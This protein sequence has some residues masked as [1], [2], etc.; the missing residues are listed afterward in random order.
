M[1]KLTGAALTLALLCMGAFA[2]CAPM[3]DI[4]GA[5]AELRRNDETHVVI[6]VTAGDEKKSLYDA[7]AV[8]AQQGDIT[9]EGSGGAGDFF[10]TSVNGTQADT[11]NFWAVY[12][13]LEAYSDATWG[14][15]E[16][17]GET[18]ASAR[19]GVSLLPLE[20]G[21]VYALVYTAI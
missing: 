15:W 3:A 11:G 2:G 7:L 21:A 13:S 1:K 10:V 12:T 5:Q 20:E 19:F 17:A 18:L 4:G 8:F 16:Y 14:T 9:L 6:E